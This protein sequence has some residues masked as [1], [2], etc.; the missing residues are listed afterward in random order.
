[1]DPF[2][3]AWALAW[4]SLLMHQVSLM[5]A[6]AMAMEARAMAEA[7]AKAKAKAHNDGK[8]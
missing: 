3:V 2:E 6:R 8:P 1:M 7:E 5:E 4:G